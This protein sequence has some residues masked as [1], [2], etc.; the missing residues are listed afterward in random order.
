MRFGEYLR[1]NFTPEWSSKYV[2]YEVMK[3]ML[4][5]IVAQM[6][7]IHQVNSNLTREEYYL[8]ADEKFFQVS[9]C[10]FSNVCLMFQ[11]CHLIL[12]Y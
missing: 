3:E 2:M 7:A 6:P 10:I 8:F 11:F 4:A 1:E 12:V 5:D 9:S